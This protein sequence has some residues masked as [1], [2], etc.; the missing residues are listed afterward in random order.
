M[1]K[2]IIFIVSI[3]S[4][5]TL[6]S[7]F[8]DDWAEDIADGVVGNYTDEFNSNL[9]SPTPTGHRGVNEQILYE[10][11]LLEDVL[12]ENVLT[13]EILRES[14]I[15]KIE[16][17]E[18]LMQEDIVIETLKVEIYDDISE[19]EEDFLCE[20]Y[21]SVDLDYSFIRQRI[22]AGC[23]IV[24]TEIVFDTAS[25]V[26]DICT[27]NW[28]GLALDAG[29]MI[30]TAGG[31][32]LSAFISAQIA[33]AKSL[34]AGNSYEMAMYDALYEGANAFYYTA[35]SIDTVNT[36]I[37]TVQ[38]VDLAA[39]AVKGVVK[40]IKNAVNG[41]EIVSETGQVI[42]KATS[43]SFKIT[44]DGVEKTC[45]QAVGSSL[46]GNAIIDLYDANQKYVASIMKQGEKLVQVSRSIPNEIL[47][48]A[49]KNAGKA[50]YVIEGANIFKVT[51]TNAGE[52]TKTICGSIDQ[53]GFVKNNYGQIIKK[54]DFTTGKELNGFSKLSSTPSDNKITI[55]VFGELVEITD[56]ST[57]ATKPLVK[58]TV[59]NVVTYLDS[60]NTKVLTEYA[61]T[62]GVT[63]IKRFS[64]VASDNGKVCGSIVDDAF[65]VGWK[66]RLD[67]IR[68][69]ATKTIRENLVNYVRNNNINL[70]RQNFPE[71]TL[72][73]IDYIKEYGRIPTSIQIHHIKNV[74]NFPDLAGDYSNLVVVSKESHLLLHGGDFHNMSMTKPDFYVDL[75]WLFNLF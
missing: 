61:G 53:G 34:E 15:T 4:L 12:R 60:S 13:E 56:A 33:K 35:V 55:N 24:L 28:A 50:K 10:T 17:D 40:W 2:I 9:N 57:N 70:V 14:V 6:S 74:A 58:K 75:K 44:V 65:D 27:F 49:G 45:K 69:N 39:K 37:S 71:L 68:S 16:N 43:K 32:S 46:D 72:E 36:I 64:D 52:A 23:S 11:V 47:M 5:I 29:Q 20:S 3:I 42:G 41:V 7:C 31:T 48:K 22:A 1:R 19:L 21:H 54:I 25:C 66:S 38:L 26:V 18:F 8:I 62:D 30:V 73:M 59:S 51:Y 67:S 63:Y